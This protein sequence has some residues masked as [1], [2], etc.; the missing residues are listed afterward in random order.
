MFA[1]KKKQGKKSPQRNY[2][3]RYKPSVRAKRSILLYT[4]LGFLG[5]RVGGGGGVV[6]HPECNF[7]NKP[8]IDTSYITLGYSTFF[9]LLFSLF[10]RENIPALGDQEGW[11]SGTQRSGP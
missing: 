7:S 4:K 3:A 8:M 10:A 5:R 11:L 2:S 1:D 6:P 9:F